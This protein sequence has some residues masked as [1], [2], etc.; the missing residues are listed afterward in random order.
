M[1]PAMPEPATLDA[2]DRLLI[3]RLQHGIPMTP[4]PYQDLADELGLDEPSVLARLADLLERGVLSR[5]GPMYHAER[6]GGGLTLA[7]MA[8]PEDDFERVVERV[9]SYAEVAHNYRR[10]HHLNMWFVIATDRVQRVQE[11]IDAIARDC[12]YAVV[13]LPKE[14]E[15]HVRLHLSV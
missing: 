13:N 11:V 8:V 3:N 7:A 15:Y 4:R 2:L 14:E 6:L 9:N 10:E 5:L 1:M 12:G